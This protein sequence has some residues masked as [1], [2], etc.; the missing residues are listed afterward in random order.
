MPVIEAI[1]GQIDDLRYEVDEIADKLHSL[2]DDCTYIETAYEI[3]E[4]HGG[5]CRRPVPL[6]PVHFECGVPGCGRRE[7]Y[8]ELEDKQVAILKEISELADFKASV[9][10]GAVV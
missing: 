9:L 1:E 2:C 5:L 8:E 7:E 4:Y 3:E 10:E 6:C